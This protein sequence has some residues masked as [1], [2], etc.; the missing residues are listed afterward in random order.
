MIGVLNLVWFAFVCWSETVSL[1]NS[2]MLKYTENW[3]TVLKQFSFWTFVFVLHSNWSKCASKFAVF[4]NSS[5][6]FRDT[7]HKITV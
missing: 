3:G 5:A 7:V 1:K 2:D 4:S 6:R